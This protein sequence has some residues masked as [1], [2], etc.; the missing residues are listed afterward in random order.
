V[1]LRMMAGA[2]GKLGS[3]QWSFRSSDGSGNGILYIISASLTRAWRS[4][5]ITAPQDEGTEKTA[6]GG[7][8]QFLCLS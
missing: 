5:P 4:Y 3:T 6:G 7:P 2:A 8:C 1:A